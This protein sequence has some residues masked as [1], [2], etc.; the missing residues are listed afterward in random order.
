MGRGLRKRDPL[1]QLGS[2]RRQHAPHF[3]HPNLLRYLT[4][5][6]LVCLGSGVANASIIATSGTV[7]LDTSPF[8]LASDSEIFVFDEQRTA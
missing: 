4:L 2:S 3:A 6:S 1:A 7:A 8:P 5:V